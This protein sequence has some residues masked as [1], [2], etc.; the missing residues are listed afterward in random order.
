MDSVGDAGS[1]RIDAFFA[2]PAAREDRWRE[3]VEVATAWRA[4]KVTRDAF[5]GA[6]QGAEVI[7]EFH[8]YPGPHLM[9]ALRSR[10]RSD[11]AD[12]AKVLAWRISSALLTR[13]FRQHAAD[14]EPDADI[15]GAVPDV[16]PPSLG[17]RD[18][19]PPYFETLIVTGAPA[20]RWPAICVEW[21]RLRRPHDEFVYE[22][23]IVGSAEDALC[24]A[25]LNPDIAAV[26]INDGFAFRSR[27]DAPV[28]RSVID[29]LA[30]HETPDL[31]ALRFA[32]KS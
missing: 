13:S 17:R 1:R 5:E 12:G 21:R 10:A 19:A 7:E 4:G 24:A 26:V 16:L 20:E 9:A 27:H 30:M 2:T 22:P 15:S 23:V 29:P 28:L 32:R 8:A 11:D 3:L 18:I 25:M 31:S 14:W 6:L